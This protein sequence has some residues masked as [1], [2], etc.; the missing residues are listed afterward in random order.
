MKTAQIDYDISQDA[1]WLIHGDRRLLLPIEMTSQ[2]NGLLDSREL[3]ELPERE[4]R[5]I[6]ETGPRPL[7][8]V[9]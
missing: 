9:I 5:G 4:R 8:R 1:Y 7:A 3:A 6:V 2:I